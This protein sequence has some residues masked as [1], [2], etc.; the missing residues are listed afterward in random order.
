MARAKSSAQNLGKSEIEG[1]REFKA[2]V[3]QQ[4]LDL[5]PFLSEESQISVAIQVNEPEKADGTEVHEELEYTLTLH[6]KLGN[7]QLD[8]EGRDSNRYTALSNAKQQMLRQLTS[9]VGSSIDS[10]ERNA[11]IRALTRGGLTLH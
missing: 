2:H 11:H 9:L 10:R 1:D 3:Y 7:F 6:A 5:Q 8:A 4:L